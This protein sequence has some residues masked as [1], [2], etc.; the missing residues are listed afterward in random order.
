MNPFK[1][2]CYYNCKGLYFSVPSL[3]QLNFPSISFAHYQILLILLKE[4]VII[5]A[6]IDMIIK[7]VK[8]VELNT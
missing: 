7:N 6:H 5:H 2:F 4:F 1:F 3:R 8:R